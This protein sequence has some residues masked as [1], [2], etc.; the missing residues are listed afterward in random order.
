MREALPADGQE[1]PPSEGS[2]VL[3]D[4][5]GGI[6][7]LPSSRRPFIDPRLHLFH[8]QSLSTSIENPSPN[9]IHAEPPTKPVALLGRPVRQRVQ[10]EQVQGLWKPKILKAVGPEERTHQFG[11][12]SLPSCRCCLLADFSTACWRQLRSSNQ[13]ALP[14][15]KQTKGDRVRVLHCS[16]V[17]YTPK[18]N[19][20]A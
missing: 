15:A 19:H 12:P 20:A 6:R 5:S 8:G 1:V 10:H 7:G 13:A 17:P 4:Q 18:H 16:S 3:P 14:A 11:K 9:S 2:S